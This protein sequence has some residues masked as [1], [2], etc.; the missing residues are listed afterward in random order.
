MNAQTAE[1]V[2]AARTAI[3]SGKKVTR[4]PTGRTAAQ[5]ET[6]LK[7][8]VAKTATPE[9]AK[10]AAPKTPRPSKYAPTAR[11]SLLVAK[12]PKREGT[13]AHAKFAAFGTGCTVAEYLAAKNNGGSGEIAWCVAHKFVSV[14]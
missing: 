11:I 10:V 13:A 4:V 14:G 5:I 9:A 1:L 6:A 3:A 7:N 8:A 2:A 12:N